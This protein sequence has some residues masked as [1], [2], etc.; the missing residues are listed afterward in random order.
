MKADNRN[1]FNFSTYFVTELGAKIN[2]NKNQNISAPKIKK[3]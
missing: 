3:F 1:K 2:F